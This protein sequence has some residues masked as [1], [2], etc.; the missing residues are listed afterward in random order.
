MKSIEDVSS[1]K[2]LCKIS[3][4]I[5]SIDSIKH[6]R[7]MRYESKKVHVIDSFI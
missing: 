1:Q 2:V 5:S 6:I 4:I 7:Y 3:G